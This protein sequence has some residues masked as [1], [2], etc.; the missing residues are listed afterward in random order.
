MQIKI[1]PI[2]WYIIFRALGDDESAALRD[3][4]KGPDSSVSN[5]GITYKWISIVHSNSN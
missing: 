2:L 4:E 5:T 1:C 3:G